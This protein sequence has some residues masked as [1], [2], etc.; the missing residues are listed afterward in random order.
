MTVPIVKPQKVIAGKRVRTQRR[1][2]TMVLVLLAACGSGGE[3]TTGAEVAADAGCV[4][5]HTDRNTPVAPTWHGLVGSTVPL[6]DGSKVVADEAYIRRSILDPQ[7][8]IV[9]G[10]TGTMPRFRLSER[11]VDLLVEHILE[12]GE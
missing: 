3:P 11:E 12:L 9:E 10:Y 7:A 2:I 1:A 8:D 5:C 4:A 6:E